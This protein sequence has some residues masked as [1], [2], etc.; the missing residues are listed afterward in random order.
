LAHARIGHLAQLHLRT[1]RLR[2]RN[3]RRLAPIR[4]N[5]GNELWYRSQLTLIV[6]ALR[7]AGAALIGEMRDRWPRLTH[8]GVQVGDELAPGLEALINRALS[9]FGN[10]KAVAERLASLAARKNL[11][12]VDDRLASEILKSVGVNI[13][14]ALSDMGR[15]STAMQ[16]ATRANVALITSIPEQ[17]FERLGKVI[18]DGWAGGRRWED[19]AKDVA[20]VG[21]VTDSRAAIIARDQTSKMNAAFNEVRQTSLGIEQYDW[22]GALD[23]RERP[24]HRAMEGRRL[25]WDA[26][27]EVDGEAVHPGEAILCRCVAIPVFNLDE[28]IRGLE[29]E[30]EEAAA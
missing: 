15:I 2:R 7:R 18:S 10:I 1:A 9:R 19:V 8:D 17:Y 27:P 25:R 29:V 28:P 11:D 3:G 21:D 12:A 16:E 13:R 22:S 4:P 23:A 26:P 6:Q 14:P 24:S 30:S 5:H 20:E